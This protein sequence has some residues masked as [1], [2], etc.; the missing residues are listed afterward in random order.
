MKLTI[1]KNGFLR[2][3]EPGNNPR[4]YE[5]Q[6]VV[7]NQTPWTNSFKAMR[8]ILDR[9]ASEQLE[10]L[11]FQLSKLNRHEI[12]HARLIECN[13]NLSELWEVY[14][15]VTDKTEIPFNILKYF[16]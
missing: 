1:L 8:I 7:P 4:T 10:D 12:V 9:L 13:F 16:E 15:S 5:C 14:N 6:W 11:T 2:M 3:E